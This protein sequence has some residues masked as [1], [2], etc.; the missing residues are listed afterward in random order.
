MIGLRKSSCGAATSLLLTLPKQSSDEGGGGRA[1]GR[2]GRRRQERSAASL[3]SAQVLPLKTIAICS[4]A[5]ARRWR[6]RSW[7]AY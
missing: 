4:K 3:T 5:A 2:R 6:C 1:L 7:V